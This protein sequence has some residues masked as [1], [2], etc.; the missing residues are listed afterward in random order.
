MKPTLRLG[1]SK[2]ALHE[3][4][5]GTVS[6]QALQRMLGIQ[7]LS[8][9]LCWLAP[10]QETVERVVGMGPALCTRHGG[11]SAHLLSVVPFPAV[12]A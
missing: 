2:E 3:L 12:A 6:D 8:H 11:S 4:Q 10:V 5:G 1:R 7:T 9:P